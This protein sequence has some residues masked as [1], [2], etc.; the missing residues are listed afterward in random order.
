MQTG[1][2]SRI[3]NWW[4]RKG[5]DEIDM[6]A[7]NDFNKTGVVAEIKRNPQKLNLADLQRKVAALPSEFTKYHFELRTLSM[8]N[9]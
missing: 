5:E 3:G 1:R 7:L 2:F 8:G 9:M 6:V 4:N